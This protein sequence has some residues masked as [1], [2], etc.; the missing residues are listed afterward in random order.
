MKK[1]YGF[2]SALAMLSMVACSSD[3]PANKGG[4]EGAKG[5]MY[6]SL[7]V[8]TL[9][10][11]K[12]TTPNQGSEV[13]KD[14]ENTIASGIIILTDEDDKVITAA[15]ITEF[16]AYQQTFATSFKMVRAT[17]QE[18]LDDN[19]GEADLHVYFIANPST[20]LTERF[21]G[22]NDADAI[23][24][25]KGQPI[26]TTITLDADGKFWA[27]NAF[28]MTNA[29]LSTITLKSEDI[30]VGKHAT[31]DDALR[32]GD[33]TVQRAMSRFDI[34][35]G[36]NTFTVKDEGITDAKVSEVTVTFDAVALVNQ[37][38]VANLFK[39]TGA[40]RPAANAILFADETAEN[41][42]FAPEQSTYMF[43]MF[44]TGAA[45]NGTLTG[46][47]IDLS[48]LDFTTFTEIK[49]E[50]NNF[51]Y[52]YD[53][54]D[55]HRGGVTGTMDY[56]KW[57]YAMPT[58]P[59]TTADTY[60]SAQQNGNT[61]GIVFRAKMT[62]GEAEITENEPVYAYGRTIYGTYE[63][64]ATYSERERE[65]LN[66]V[67]VRFHQALTDAG[68][69]ADQATIDAK[70]VARGFNIYRPNEDGDIYCY[71]VYWNRHNDNGLPTAMGIMEFGAVRNNIYKLSVESV[72]ALGHPGNPD[73]DNDEFKPEDP[74]EEEEFWGE[75][76]CRILDWE[77]RINGIKF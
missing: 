11:S 60:A 68:E 77:V 33:V 18:F 66:G 45:T 50:D 9:G 37:A 17:L 40:T 27:N 54:E 75:V 19:D 32:L 10:G 29:E 28:L 56:F 51:D 62:F 7:T 49:E 63:D 55:D 34:A 41:Y 13:G 15:E 4:E 64:L 44:G 42:V 3:E 69:G 74:D 70:L 57:R 72:Y 31:K 65:N 39:Q 2:L 61:L 35:T 24:D 38:T 1:I 76:V 26:Q 71:Y 48:S 25:I 5:D 46:R 30:A 16:A 23:D 47:Q 43:P 53:A 14:Y 59:V 36:S 22:T 20:E 6:M 8:R 73:D 67:A 21:L 58:V 52:D 12:T